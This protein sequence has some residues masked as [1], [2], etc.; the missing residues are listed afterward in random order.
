MGRFTTTKWQLGLAVIVGISSICWLY[1][2]GTRPS[3]PLLPHVSPCKALASGMKRV[4]DRG[5]QFD[6]STKDFSISEGSSDAAP[7]VHGFDLVPKQ[8]NAILKIEFGWRPMESITP[9]PALTFLKRIERRP[10]FDDKGKPIGEDKWGYLDTG[11]R[12]RSVRFSGIGTA[13]YGLVDRQA[14]EI[15]DRV[16]NSVCSVQN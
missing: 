14:A 10:I 5:F 7:F 8:S 15:F 11:E 16:I 13:K 12:W 1:F 4:G 3:P 6:V 9:D 2:V